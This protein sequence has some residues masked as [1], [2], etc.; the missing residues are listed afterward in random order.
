M[1]TALAA[2]LGASLL[3]LAPAGAMAQT[4]I[5]FD[6]FS[7][8]SLGPHWTTVPDPEYATYTVSNGRLT[9]NWIRTPLG[10]PWGTVNNAPFRAF[11]G[12]HEGDFVATIRLG[13]ESGAQRQIF[14]QAHNWGQSR[15]LGEMTYSDLSGNVTGSLGGSG[16]IVPNV[17]PGTHD[18]RIARV[19]ELMHF[20]LNNQHFG[21]MTGWEL[22]IDNIAFNIQFIAPA[23]TFQ[24][25]YFESV[26]IVP[27][28]ASALLATGFTTMCVM[29]RRR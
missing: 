5:F 8:T 6:D 21:S 19:G 15:N 17:A 25:V 14:V 1:N 18:F 2:R 23:S 13:W 27:S 10:S 4:P 9:V 11:F 28:P 29:R 12:P 3:L 24:P 22:P 20:S 7:G 16:F 26:L